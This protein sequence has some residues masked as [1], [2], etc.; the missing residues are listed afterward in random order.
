M[1]KT[2]IDVDDVLLWHCQRILGTTTKKGTANAALR[3]VVR[4][5][6]AKQFLERARAGI[7]LADI[8]SGQADHG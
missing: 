8:G 5:D 2:L 6:A 1:T 4:R 3:E 7:F